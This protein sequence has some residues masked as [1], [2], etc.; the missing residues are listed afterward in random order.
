MTTVSAQGHTVMNCLAVARRVLKVPL[1]GHREKLR[2]GEEGLYRIELESGHIVECTL[3][4][5]AKS[6]AHI[7]V[8]DPMGDWHGRNE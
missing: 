6:E 2:S 7:E 1:Q 4:K 8:E 3:I 5:G